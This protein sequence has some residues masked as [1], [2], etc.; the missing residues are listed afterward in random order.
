MSLRMRRNK[1]RFLSTL[2]AEFST[3][4]TPAGPAGPEVVAVTVLVAGAST[5]V[6]DPPAVTV[7]VF[8]VVLVV[9]VVMRCSPR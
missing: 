3:N 5:T 6:V 4:P 7:T 2:A 1:Q 8:V 9:T